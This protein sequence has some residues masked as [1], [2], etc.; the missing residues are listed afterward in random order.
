MIGLK[1]DPSPLE[2][3]SDQSISVQFHPS[4]LPT[5]KYLKRWLN[6]FAEVSDES[7]L[8]DL[9]LFYS[10]AKRKHLDHRKPLHLARIVLS[11]YYTRRKLLSASALQSSTRHSVIRWVP[12][13]LIFPFSRK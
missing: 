12:T 5:Y 4:F 6:R 13:D 9:I 2:E 3:K 7:I 1:L 8:N 11:I 10:L